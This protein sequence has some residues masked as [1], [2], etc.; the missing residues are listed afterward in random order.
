[1]TKTSYSRESMRM[2]IQDGFDA[3][4]F[5][6]EPAQSEPADDEEPMDDHRYDDAHNWRS[7]PTPSERVS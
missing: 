4:K 5:G 6:N 3:A 7:G 1:M 2:A